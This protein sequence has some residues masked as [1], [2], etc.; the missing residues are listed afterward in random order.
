MAFKL[1][2]KKVVWE[3]AGSNAFTL[4]YGNKLTGGVFKTGKLWYSSTRVGQSKPVSLEAAKKI[5]VEQV[6][7]VMA[8]YGEKG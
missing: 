6:P 8:S 4:L 3:P 5:C 7:K 2:P 1:D